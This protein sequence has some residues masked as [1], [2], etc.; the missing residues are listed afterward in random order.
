MNVN[1]DLTIPIKQQKH[2]LVFS[3]GSCTVGPNRPLNTFL[4]QTPFLNVDGCPTYKSPD[5]A[6]VDNS[7]VVNPPTCPNQSFTVSFQITNQGDIGLSGNVPISFYNGNPTQPGAIKLSTIIVPLNNFEVDDIEPITN[8]SVSGPGGPFTLYIV[9]NDA[10]TTVPT[11]ISLPNTNFLE[12]DYNDN[13]ISA[14]V[15]PLP[16]GITAVK[17]QDNIKCVGSSSPNNGAIRAFVPKTGG[18]E[19]TADYNFYWSIGNVAKPVPADYSGA[20]VNNIPEGVYTVYAIHKTANCS[21]ISTQVTVGRIDKAIAVSIALV[22]ADDNCSVPNGSLR[23]IVNDTDGDGIGE[24]PGNFNYVWYE[25]NDIFTDP[26]VSVSYLATGLKARTYTVVVTDPITG[27]QSINS[28]TVPDETVKPVVSASSVNIICSTTNSGSVSA[29]IGGVTTGFAF[30]WYR[31]N[32]I[33]PSPDFTGSTVNNVPTGNYTVVATATASQCESD[34][35]TVTVNQSSKPV[36]SASAIAPMTSC[37]VAFPNGSATVSVP[38][39]TST[40]S[41]EWFRGQNTV[42]VNRVS[43]NANATGLSAGIYTAKVTDTATGCFQTAEVTISF[44]V[45]TPSLILAAVSDLTNCI[46]PNGSVFVNVTLD[47]PADYI[48]NWY[49]GASVKATHDYPDQDNVL[50]NLL[51]G[52]YTVQAVHRTKNCITAPIQ[53]TVADNTPTILINLN[54]SITV[55]P[56]DCTSPDGIMQVSV[57]APGNSS[58]FNVQWFFGTA[59]FS[60]AAVRTDNSVYTSTATGLQTGIYTVVSTN[61]DNGCQ[62][63]EEFNLP[64]ADAHSL[65]FISKVN[66]NKCTPVN[67]GEITVL[68]KPTPLAGFDEGDYDIQLYSGTN[69]TGAPI[70]VITG[71]AGVSQ[72][73]TNNNL[74]PG[75][76]NLVAISKNILT[77]DCKSVPLLVEIEQIVSFPSIVASQI[78]ANTNCTGSTANG[79]IEINIDGVAPETNYSFAWFEG[80]STAS[81]LLGTGTSGVVVGN[82]EIANNL[83][84][85]IYTVEV[86]NTTPTSTGCSSTATFQIFDNPPVISIAEADLSVTDVTLCS[87]PNGASVSVNAIREGPSAGLLANYTF[88][89]FD[90]NQN[91]LPNAGTPNTTNTISNLPAGT[92]FVQATKNAGANG[93][94]CASALVEFEILDKTIVSV[95]VD[96]TSIV[97]PTRCLQP[98]NITGELK[99]LASGNSVTGYSYSWHQGP[100]TGFPVVSNNPDLI[101]ITIPLGQTD[102]TYTIDVMNNS[103]NCS[104]TATYVLPLEIVP[105]AISASASS[106]TFCSSDNGGVFATVTS[107]N[108]NNYTYQWYIGNAVKA[109]TDFTGKQNSNLPAGD[110]T[111]VAVDQS[112]VFCA[113][114]PQTVTLENA[115]ILPAITATAIEPLTMCDPARPDGVASATVNGDIINYTFDWYQGDPTSGA[116]IFRGSE[117]N[118]LQAITYSVIATNIVTGCSDVT[119]VTIDQ[120]ILPVPAPQVSVLSHVTSCIESNGALEASVDGNTRD[121][122]FHWYDTN[123]G[124]APDTASAD[125]RGEIYSSLEVGTYYVSATSRMTGCIS[126]PA[127]NTIMNAPVYP[128]F[129]FKVEPASCEANDGFLAIYM[130]NN[131]DISS[132]VWDVNGTQVAGPNLQGI[133]AGTYSVTVTSSLGCLT[134]KQMEVATE[135]RPFNGV[136][137]NGDGK[138]DIFHINCIDSFPTNLVK[139]FNRAGTLVYEAGGYDNIDIYFDGKS[140]KGISLMGSNLPDG[141]YFY[142][143]DKGNGSKPVAGYL[144]IVN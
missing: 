9:L 28:F 111:I 110:Y 67:T 139:I 132:V 11:P 25:G 50:N 45:V 78:D 112:D 118:N 29:N 123:P 20:T 65:N 52:T 107:G 21:S 115:Q 8:I 144:E 16:V 81:P 40:Y 17:I 120:S 122:I 93:L 125:F 36:I 71:V 24:P 95:N 79:L 49:N 68:L 87:N 10:G 57:S 70:Q 85:G 86:T 89:W 44:A 27:C 92:Y 47:T 14:P 33:K 69:D 94:S 76:Y 26:Q 109:T 63:F 82:G 30:D 66:V 23:A 114:V 117:I 59:P 100:D 127:N 41:F 84:V 13:I 103:N 97:K 3:T 116:P 106:L 135:I 101:G 4:N 104:I 42:A 54:A 99:A 31:G 77:L 15:N 56:S 143:I 53:A 124:A 55:L 126:G 72:Y 32:V 96:L 74:I 62:A 80:P 141:T 133:P 39:G 128:D 7:L 37:D 58:G 113:S 18:G 34:P 131:V 46:T 64:F 138:N 90:A 38:G 51:V 60:G 5:L 136:S 142:I 61:R 73:T 43:T 2:H 137:R 19:N 88:L 35:V 75:F 83:P 98:A 105:I 22:R 119:Q 140:N 1:D 12:C 129:D 102:I 91:V 134:T 121:Y 130:R 6:Y 48:F 108:S